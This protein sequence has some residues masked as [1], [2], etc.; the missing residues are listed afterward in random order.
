MKKH[1]YI[2]VLSIF[3]S[4]VAEAQLPNGS[5]AP[6][7]TL[8]DINGVEH[9]LY[10]YLDDGYTVIIDFSA[11]WCS[12][13]WDYHTSGELEELYIEHGPTGMPNVSDSTTDDVMV[14][15]IEGDEDTTFDELNGIGAGTMGD[16]VT[17]TPYPIIDDHTI[18]ELYELIFWPTLYTICPDRSITTNFPITADEHYEAVGSCGFASF[19]IDMTMVGLEST[20]QMC[21]T[22]YEPVLKI[23]NYS[24]DNT[25]TSAVISASQGALILGTYDWTG[26]LE[27][28]ESDVFEMPTITG[29]DVN[30]PVTFTVSVDGDLDTSNDAIEVILTNAITSATITLDLMTDDYA[31]ETSWDIKDDSDVVIASGSGYENNTLTSEEI[32][33][34]AIGCY[35]FTI[36]DSYGDGICCT[37]GEGYYELKDE[38]GIVL[39]SGG[40]IAPSFEGIFEVIELFENDEVTGISEETVSLISVYPNPVNDELF[41]RFDSKID[42]SSV[43]LFDLTGKNTGVVLVNGVMNIKQ[44][45]IG[46]YI[47][48][49][50]TSTDVIT[51]KIVKQ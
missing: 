7:W 10:E 44:L 41:I 36:Y 45:P 37:Y 3:F 39:I 30:T 25:I 48:N 17:G 31:E 47:L 40:E 19:A 43:G 32:S 46:I 27:T 24:L 14:F 2:I 15:F 50:N 16:W 8:T 22:D 33:L 20:T 13:C 28:F 4:I 38:D 5:T 34:P 42:V 18:T 23:K 6:D 51:K 49:V 1:L 11:T 35:T 12:P 9:T 29:I 26:S 21:G